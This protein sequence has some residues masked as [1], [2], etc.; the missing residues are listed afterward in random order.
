MAIERFSLEGKVALVT[1]ASSGIGY[2]LAQGLA[3]A[4]ATVVAAARRVERLEAL[5]SGINGAGGRAIA[6]ALDVTSPES[7][8]SAF[9][10]AN[11][12]VGLCD[13]IVNNAGIAAPR[14]FLDIDEAS[15]DSVL[16]TNLKGVWHVSQEAARRLVEAQRPGSIVNIASVLGLGAKPSYSTYATSKGAV[17]QLTRSLANDLMRYGIRVNAVA[18][19]WFETEMNADFFASEKGQ[20]Y[21]HTMPARRLGQLDELIGPVMLLASDAGS[22][23][24]GAVLPVDGALHTRLI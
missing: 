22:F 14:P 9:D 23:V 21:I 16:D 24:N 17:L 13:I 8:R 12:E 15:L 1:G 10:A 11:A 6:V 4:G 7:V 3:A 18:P 5:V 2:R 19:G 20:A